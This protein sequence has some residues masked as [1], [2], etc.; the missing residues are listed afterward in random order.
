MKSSNALKM[1]RMV[2][3]TRQHDPRIITVKRKSHEEMV[4][5]KFIRVITLQ[6]FSMTIYANSTLSIVQHNFKLYMSTQEK[7][8]YIHAV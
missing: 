1:M 8:E 3:K 2:M 7:D 5:L 6:L 4:G